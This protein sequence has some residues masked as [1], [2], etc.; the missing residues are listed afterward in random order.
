MFI[1]SMYSRCG[2]RRTCCSR[3]MSTSVEGRIAPVKCRCRCALGSAARSRRPGGVGTGAVRSGT[4]R[5]SIPSV[6]TQ[7]RDDVADQAGALGLVEELVVG[8]VD[9]AQ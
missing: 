9:D 7:P 6:L 5:T 8:A 2:G 4:A 1:G 3:A